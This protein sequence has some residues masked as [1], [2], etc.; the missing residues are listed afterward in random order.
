MAGGCSLKFTVISTVLSVFGSR[1]FWVQQSTRWSTS[2]RYA[3]S[4]PL[5]MRPITAVSS[6][7][8]RRFTEGSKEMQAFA[9][10]EK[11]SGKRTQPRPTPGF[12]STSSL[13]TS[14]RQVCSNSVLWW[15][16]SCR[17]GWLWSIWNRRGLHTALEPAGLYKSA[18]R[19]DTLHP[20]PHSGNG[21]VIPQ[22]K[23]ML[24]IA[25]TI[26]CEKCGEESQNSTSTWSEV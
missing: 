13:Q 4:S 14:V 23:K 16:V 20:I 3:D 10:R 15:W 8:F 5:W 18:D 2:L 19:R 7:N 21:L 26:T 24:H 22:V 1:L 9:Y 11:S 17:P 6:A 25:C 12:Q